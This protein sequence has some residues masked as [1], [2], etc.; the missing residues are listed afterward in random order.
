MKV[1]YKEGRLIIESE[2]AL[3][4]AFVR[5]YFGLNEDLVSIYKNIDVDSV[6]H[7][8]VIKFKG[9]R[10]LN[11]DRWECL[12][13]YILSSNNNIPRIKNMIEALSMHF[14]RRLKLGRLER[15]SFPSAGVIAKASL[16]ELRRLGLGFRAGYLSVAAKEIS[17]KRL[18]LTAL[19]GLKYKDA[20]E[21]LIL[22][23]GVGDKISDCV[24]LFSFKKYEAFPVDVW[25]KR[26]MERSYFS[27]DITP[28]KRLV[29]FARGHFG[30]YAG[31]AQE[32]LYHYFR[33]RTDK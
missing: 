9:L 11:Q 28:I 10:I 21:R 3:K 31:Y 24:L 4:K 14:G 26:G 19:E 13:S 15:Y 27:G 20:K 7:D 2:D 23:K 1:D 25:I 33:H 8:A 12:A 22:L 17:S 29:E 18:D 30:G 16:N 5:E 6:I 32:Y